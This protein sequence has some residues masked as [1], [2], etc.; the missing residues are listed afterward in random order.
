MHRGTADDRRGDVEVR[1]GLILDSNAAIGLFD[2]N[3]AVDAA[4]REAGRIFL[5]AVAYGEIMAGCQGMTRRE[6][7]TRELLGI[8]LG[9]PDVSILPVTKATGGFY[10][11][12]YDYLRS[13][14]RKIPVNDIWIAAAALETGAAICTGDTHLL[15][16]P[17]IR[18]VPF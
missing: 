17:L 11:R 5:P 7:R 3:A 16:L 6:V 13:A 1:D 4:M 9:K 15:G 10:G 12:I 8:L 2:G 18:T 14:G